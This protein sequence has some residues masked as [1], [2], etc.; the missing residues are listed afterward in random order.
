M[1]LNHDEAIHN[2]QD[3]N[4]KLNNDIG[5]NSKSHDASVKTYEKKLKQEE[6]QRDS[7]QKQLNDVKSQNEEITKLLERTKTNLAAAFQDR[8]TLQVT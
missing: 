1:D 2:L 7:F 3:L 5:I 6:K 4:E 8:A